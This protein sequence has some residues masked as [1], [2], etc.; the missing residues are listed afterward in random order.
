MSALAR[1]YTHNT[2]EPSWFDYKEGDIPIFEANY[3]VPILWVALFSE[4]HYLA[5]LDPEGDADEPEDNRVPCLVGQRDECLSLLTQRY[6]YLV[7]LFQQCG[8]ILDEFITAIN[9]LDGLYLS[10]EMSEVFYMEED[11][12]AFFRDLHHVLM[13][14]DAMDASALEALMGLADTIGYDQDMHDYIPAEPTGFR[15]YRYHA[16]GLAVSG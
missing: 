10:I 12:E 16:I 1:L 7:S 3:L 4:K 13:M 11:S 9:A 2:V 6:D 15:D 8:D 14:F 5:W